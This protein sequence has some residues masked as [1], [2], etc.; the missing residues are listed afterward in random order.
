MTLFLRIHLNEI[1]RVIFMTQ[2]LRIYL[3]KMHRVVHLTLCFPKID[4][5]QSARTLQQFLRGL[6]YQRMYHVS[7]QA[8]WEP[9]STSGSFISKGLYQHPLTNLNRLIQILTLSLCDITTCL[10]SQTSL[11]QNPPRINIITKTQNFTLKS[12][13]FFQKLGSYYVSLSPLFTL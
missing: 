2:C 4:T 7:M 3:N 9:I 10:S 8:T 6:F 12:I 5:I 13:N 1:H 11:V